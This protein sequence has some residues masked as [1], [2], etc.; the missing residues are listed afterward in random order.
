MDAS[1][2]AIMAE[3]RGLDVPQ[4]EFVL[5]CLKMLNA[6][7]DAAEQVREWWPAVGA[8]PVLVGGELAG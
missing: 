3:V 6:D 4:L 1:V 7:L 2:E 5:N 8:E